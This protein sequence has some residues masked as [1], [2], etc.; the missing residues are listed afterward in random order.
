[1]NPN[2]PKAAFR[3]D[4]YD[5][6][7]SVIRT[8]MALHFRLQRKDQRD[9]PK[10]FVIGHPRTGTTALHYLFKA[11]GLNSRHTSGD[12]H[13][14]Q[15]DC[16]SDFGQVRP[17]KAFDRYYQNAKFVLNT[18]PTRDYLI[19]MVSQI[20][21]NWNFTAQHFVREI[22]RRAS[23]YS[24]MLQHF[25]GRS[26]LCIVDITK[27]DAFD[28]VADFLNLTVPAESLRE[29]PNRGKKSVDSE[30]V[31]V[32]DAAFDLL[33]FDQQKANTA[34]LSLAELGV[35]SHVSLGNARIPAVHL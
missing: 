23:F 28:F 26:D 19:S 21:P 34:F 14:S 27:P 24:N 9:K 16:F 35:D 29:P 12:W 6:M 8:R 31:K 3:Y 25:K 13:T 18:R 2:L 7:L 33:G 20:H 22:F 10:T 5:F 30:K 17:I 32:I 11:N 15:F 1:M 4:R